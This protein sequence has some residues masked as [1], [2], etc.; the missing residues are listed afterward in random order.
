[1]A[2]KLYVGNVNYDTN[3]ETLKENFQQYGEV[4]SVSMVTDR[5]TGMFRGFAFVEMGTEDEAK[6]AI[7]GLNGTE[8]DGR[9]IRVDEARERPRRD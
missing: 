7:D 1:M 4:V 9:A 8:I 2:T 6:A 5:Y 3:E